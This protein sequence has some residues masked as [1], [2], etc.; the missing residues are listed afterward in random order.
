[1]QRIHAKRIAA[2][3]AAWLAG[4]ADADALSALVQLLWLCGASDHRAANACGR[5]PRAQVPKAAPPIAAA[6]YTYD[7]ATAERRTVAGTA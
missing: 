3:C 4:A 2:E 1:M 5:A 7:A 6:W